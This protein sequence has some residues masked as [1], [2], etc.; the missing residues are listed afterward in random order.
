MEAWSVGLCER[1]PSK[2][3]FSGDAASLPWD[4]SKAKT[5]TINKHVLL[6]VR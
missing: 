6:V 4:G 1:T 5:Y 3:F 2:S